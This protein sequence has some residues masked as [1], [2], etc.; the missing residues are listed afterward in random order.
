MNE[1][2]N[3][4]EPGDYI[5]AISCIISIIAA[6]LSFISYR[7]SK[8]EYNLQVKLYSDGLANF[9]FNVIDACIKDNKDYDK[10]QYWF[11]LLITNLSDKQTSI[12]EYS[13]RLECLSNVVYKPEYILPDN[14]KNSDITPLEMPQNIE[15][16]SSLKG[17]CV[18]ELPRSTFEE[19]DIESCSIT[20]KD[21][22]K[23]TDSQ[24]PI[25]IKEELVNYDI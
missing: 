1:I 2:L 9:N 13:L 25:Y 14:M 7:L 16:H 19:L 24:T 23:S 4:M 11:H 22:H 20:L 17:W 3:S 8:K 21:M 10:I 18:F 5:S 15:A 6:I 12:V